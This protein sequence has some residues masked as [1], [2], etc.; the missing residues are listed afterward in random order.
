MWIRSTGACDHPSIMQL[1][2]IETRDLSCFCRGHFRS[3]CGKEVGLVASI[4]L[5]DGQSDTFHEQMDLREF[6]LKLHLLLLLSEM[7]IREA[8]TML[9]FAQPPPPQL[10]PSFSSS[11]S[12]HCTTSGPSLPHRH[13]RGTTPMLLR[14][15]VTSALPEWSS[16]PTY[17]QT[18]NF[19]ATEVFKQKER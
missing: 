4:P 8:A 2:A 9:F 19:T 16:A 14:L 13:S 18:S 6:D 10:V 1:H 11:L 5:S 7:A 15:L 12:R 3:R 17:R